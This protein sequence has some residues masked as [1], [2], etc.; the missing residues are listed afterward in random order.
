MLGLGSD[1]HLVIAVEP[2]QAEL[3]GGLGLQGAPLLNQLVALQCDL[4]LHVDGARVEFGGGFNQD[5]RDGALY[6]KD[7]KKSDA[8]TRKQQNA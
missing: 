4:L 1:H 5:G 6:F 3:L 7:Q 2:A 8:E